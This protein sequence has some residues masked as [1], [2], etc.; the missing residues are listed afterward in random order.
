MRSVPRY[1]L[2]LVPAL[3]LLCSACRSVQAP[4]AAANPPPLAPP[5][6]VRNN[7]PPAPEAPLHPRIEVF[8]AAPSSIQPGQRAVLRW[9][10]AGASEVQLEPS[11]RGLRL[12]LE[13][14]AAVSPANTTSY[15]LS[16]YGLKS[17]ATASASVIV[18]GASSGP[19]GTPKL[20]FSDLADVYF[21]LNRW[22]MRSE[23]TETLS[24]NARLLRSVVESDGNLRIS[25][26]G[27][28]DQ[29][30]SAE[31]NLA[32][33]EQRAAEVRRQLIEL[34]LPEARLSTIS[35]GNE[36]PLCEEP[37]E[38]CRQRNRRVHLSLH[39]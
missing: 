27:Y 4:A 12:P 2:A 13:G 35:W 7:P 28:C 24:T 22:D 34:G 31:Y 18:E 1:C 10:V 32:L 36:M 5:P 25:I 23:D 38:A 17:Y 11:A 16:A 6:V 26:E 37:T 19:A 3:G 39:R 9:R 14:T 33:G 15:R 20:P 30:G 21:D 8:D 29:R